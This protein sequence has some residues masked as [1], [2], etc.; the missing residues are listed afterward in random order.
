MSTK[1]TP[2]PW[3]TIDT[4]V[5]SS[6]GRL[7]CNAIKLQ[8][9]SLKADQEMHDIAVA[10]ARLIAASPE[11]LGTLQLLVA[12]IYSGHSIKMDDQHM[13]R[14]L[15]VIAKATGTTPESGESQASAMLNRGES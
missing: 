4:Y 12:A 1:H 10:N 2:G 13:T 5:E 15:D 14:A 8:G 9:K 7:V 11:L 6:F 3:R